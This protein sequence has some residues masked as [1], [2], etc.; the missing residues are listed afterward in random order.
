MATK[1]AKRARGIAK[2]EAEETERRESGLRFLRLS[3]AERSQQRAKAE[4][5]RKKRAIVKSKRLAR[6][7]EAAKES[8]PG[9]YK[10]IGEQVDVAKSS[11]KNKRKK[12]YQKARGPK[13]EV[14]PDG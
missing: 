12:Q 10:T 6:A 3:Q 5:D 11:H 2:R 13:Q 1:K 4:E 9:S 7:H 14:S 8:K